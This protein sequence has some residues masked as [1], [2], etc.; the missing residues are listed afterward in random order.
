MEISLALFIVLVVCA[1]VCWVTLSPRSR[2]YATAKRPW[3]N[4]NS[5]SEAV[6]EGYSTITKVTGKPFYVRYWAQD[7]LV[8]PSHYLQDVRRAD[9]NQ[10]NFVD[11]ISD[12]FF[13]YNW[14]GDLFKSTRMQTLVMK[15]IN[16]RLP[17]LATPMIEECA[18]AFNAELG[19]CTEPKEVLALE[20]ITSIS[21]RIIARFI[22][23][24][25]LSRD[26]RFL[27]ATNAYFGGNF[28]TGFLMLK[29]PFGAFLRD[30]IAWPLF[31][32]HQK[33]RQQRL[34][35]MIE[36]IM[37]RRMKERDL[38][39]EKPSEYDA[40][41]TLLD[42][43]DQFPLD[44]SSKTSPLHTLSHEIL[45]LVWAAGQSPAISAVAVIF[46]LLERSEYMQILTEEA[47]AAVAK[48]G[49]ADL[50]LNELPIMDSFIRETHRFH[51]AFVLNATRTV[52]GQPFTFSD[53]LTLPVGTRIAFAAESAQ[54]DPEFIKDPETFD[55]LRF[56]KLAEAD[57]R[58]EDGVNR[59][60]AS[61]TSY[62]NMTFGYGN[63]ACPGRF[64]GVRVIKIILM[65][66]LLDYDISWD[67]TDGEPPRFRMEG[68]S[69]PSPTQKVFFR[70]R[71]I[72]QDSLNP[73]MLC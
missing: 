36:P 30:T 71:K 39:V 44:E 11:S 5:V 57:V 73:T 48:Y 62:S 23:G 10:L 41:Q 42:L 70:R 9:K 28:L 58:Q 4:E 7:Y 51:P 61:H 15:G 59:W 35:E 60:A 26:Q 56:I 43:L 24:K 49:W 64:M 6:K 54:L 13:M 21:L 14:I 31:K 33:Y 1:T 66:V 18:Y 67:R 46:K 53:G 22:A 37:A 34:I 16:P 38:M 3:W 52:K 55:G 63:H 69:V 32:Y 29:L 12:V 68:L 50:A 17:K 65:R 40:I 47:Q 25:E 45:Q 20:S 8:L 72:R 27:D 19:D 2:E